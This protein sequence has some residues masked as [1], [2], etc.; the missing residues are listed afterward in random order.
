MFRDIPDRGRA[1]TVAGWPNDR[2]GRVAVASECDDQLRAVGL[3]VEDH[4]E[5]LERG[6]ESIGLPS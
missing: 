6:L 1:I 5:N 4:A 3:T 2:E